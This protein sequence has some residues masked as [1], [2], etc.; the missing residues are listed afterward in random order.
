MRARHARSFNRSWRV[1]GHPT[2]WIRSGVGGA[3][4]WYFAIGQASSLARYI[5]GAWIV[6]L[7]SEGLSA[8]V[9]VVTR[10]PMSPTRPR[11]CKAC[12]SEASPPGDDP[13]GCLH[14]SPLKAR[15]RQNPQGRSNPPTVNLPSITHLDESHRA[16]CSPKVLARS[17]QTR[18]PARERLEA[19]VSVISARRTA[20]PIHL[21]VRSFP[22][23]LRHASRSHRASKCRTR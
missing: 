17:A 7:G 23:P 11:A 15:F 8:T 13:W 5:V 6:Y 1:E 18:T 20:H 10:C 4:V 9:A 19:L 3:A 22:T 2:C 16:L 21:S 12:E 14:R